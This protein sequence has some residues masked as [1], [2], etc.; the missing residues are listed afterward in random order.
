VQAVQRV[1]RR[2]RFAG[3]AAALLSLA[4]WLVLGTGLEASGQSS[5]QSG[6]WSAAPGVAPDA[7]EDGLVVEGPDESQP[8]TFAA[9]SY[10][11][12][13]GETPESLELTV[14]SGSAS[15]PSATLALCPL[16]TGSFSPEQGGSASD[17]P[18]YDCASKVT[19]AP[20]GDPS[21]S[22]YTF[23]VGS[24]VSGEG[25]AV[26]IVPTAPGGRV[27]FDAPDAS[28]LQV[29]AGSSFS[30]TETSEF[31]SDVPSSGSEES[32]GASGTPALDAAPSSGA[33]SDTAAGDA[34][35][36][37]PQK[38]TASSAPAGGEQNLATAAATSDAGGGG[39]F[40][41][42]LFIALALAAAV[43][44]LLAGSLAGP[45]APEDG[46]EG[47]ALSDSGE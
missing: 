24:L 26:A 40:R 42:P 46:T 3:R 43:L 30:S 15:T 12:A 38:T 35:A 9:V 33:A 5:V 18:E 44:W 2:G 7:P 29:S 45:S 25:L 23:T 13:S 39:S 32:T 1:M 20:E 41:A 14:A 47:L 36:A 19:A 11:L 10:S 21:A 8:V 6:W 22:T 31:T 27:V 17:A 4:S 37:A 34:Q 28:S 16:T